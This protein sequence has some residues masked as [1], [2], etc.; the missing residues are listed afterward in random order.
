MDL[1][2]KKA[3]LLV[4]FGTLSSQQRARC[5]DKIMH[6]TKVNFPAY[7]VKN[8]FTSVFILNKLQ[9]KTDIFSLPEILATLHEEKYEEIIIQ[10]TL[11]TAG[12]EYQNKIVKVAMPYQR[13]FKR[14][15]IGRP[16]IGPDQDIRMLLQ[17]LEAQI[18]AKRDDEEIVFMGH[19]S[20][21]QYNPVYE[22]LQKSIDGVRS[23]ITIG[24]L[25]EGNCPN[26]ENVLQRL[27]RKGKNK[28][29]LMPL[30]FVAGMHVEKDMSGDEHSWKQRFL[31]QGFAVRVYE[32]GLG[33]NEAFQH[34]YIEKIRRIIE[35]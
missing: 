18:G 35:D 19:G 26:F 4:S 2:K 30:L 8:V 28:V 24:V 6:K 29:Y 7:T 23:D 12:E 11:L 22:E 27:K 25:E 21:N 5:I 17:A 9:D 14:L 1:V 15:T 20:K 3:I 32:Q 16:V 31:R 13:Q 10:P 33:E 34:I